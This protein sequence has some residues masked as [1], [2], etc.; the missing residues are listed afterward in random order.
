MLKNQ[1]KPNIDKFAGI[2]VYVSIQKKS[3]S[4]TLKVII[5]INCNHSYLFDFKVC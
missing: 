4:Q 5:E 1:C 2:C 3:W